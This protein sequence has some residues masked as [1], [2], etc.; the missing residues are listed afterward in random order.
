MFPPPAKFFVPPWLRPA[1][2]AFMAALTF[3]RTAVAA[4]PADTKPTAF[5]LAHTTNVL[6][7]LIEKAL[8][9]KSVPSISIALVR[10][11]SI[12]WKAA[13]GHSNVRTKTPATPDT[14]YNAAS[15]FKA[16][17]ATALMQ[18]AE[19]GKL[20]LDH[21]VNRYLGESPIRDRMQS[22]KSVTCTH[23]L[24]HWSGLTSFPGRTQAAMKPIWGRE[25]PKNLEQ[26]ASEIYS[27]RPPETKFEYNNHGYGLAG[28]LVE[29]ISGLEYEAYVTQ[30][31]LTPLGVSTAHPVRPSP[32]MVEVM[33]LPYDL[34]SA[35][36][37]RPA[38]QVHTDA[39][40]AGN[41]YL[42]ADDMA[43]FLGAHVNGGVFQQRRILSAASVKEMH[44][45]RFGGNYALGFRV[46]KTARS[47]TLIRHV[48]RMPGMSSMMMGDID[49]HV[50]V[51]YMANASDVPDE[52]ADA[53]I[54]LLR[55][56]SYPIAERQ[57]IDVDPLI[58]ERY[59][60]TYEVGNVVFD[61]TREDAN[62]FVQKNKNKKG[63]MLAETPT[64]FFLKGNA[65]TVNFETNSVGV[66]D[67][68][69]IFEPDWQLTIAARRQ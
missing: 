25:L 34:T 21:S 61:I 67:R 7:S 3:I 47:G 60:G 51:Y 20:N 13:F 42:T 63:K 49:T 23:L 43:R 52:I 19:Q 46:K 15:T 33:A 35:G 40:P 11:D 68:M 66:I 45:P 9:E 4:D 14:L 64:A 22:E 48:G 65:A 16:V 50:G 27:I 44:R 59:V 69:V 55:G 38:P 8:K 57:A 10:D 58:L 62:L 56:E 28:L 6:T 30:H 39:F 1:L 32:E 37:P 2:V 29:K 41:A 5:D 53:A 54:A 24:S 18:L 12:V 36:E 17:T 31:I 26:V